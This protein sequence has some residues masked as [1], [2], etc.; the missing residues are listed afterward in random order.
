[1]DISK[2][3]EK[4]ASLDNIKPVQ[5]L[6][7]SWPTIQVHII[8]L[9]FRLM[10][11]TPVILNGKMMPINASVKIFGPLMSALTITTPL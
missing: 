10:I 4:L 1:M 9:L 2:I 8:S 3:Q 6:T 7:V 5:E 11:F